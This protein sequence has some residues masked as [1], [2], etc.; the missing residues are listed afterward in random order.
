M[1]TLAEELAQLTNP[2]PV[3]HDPE[4]SDDFYTSAKVE[5]NV[6]YHD[7]YEVTASEP[8][9]LR[10]KAVV[11]LGDIDKKYAGKKTSR[12][13]LD[14]D[15]GEFSDDEI[16][17]E[18]EAS[19]DE[20]SDDSSESM[21]SGDADENISDSD[22]EGG[23]EEDAEIE[24]FQN[25][26]NLA[27]KG[28]QK[29]FSFVDDGDYSKYA[30]DEDND[31]DNDDDDDDDDDDDIEEEEMDN[32]DGIEAVGGEE[33]GISSFSKTSADE[34]VQKGQAAKYQLAQ[35]M[36]KTLLDKLIQLQTVLMLQNKE[37]EHIIT[38]DKPETLSNNTIQKWNDKTRL[39]GGK[40][41][42]KS[43]SAF[44]LSA[45]KQIEQILSD[46]DRL[47]KRTQMKR[48]VYKVLGKMDDGE[49]KSDSQPSDTVEEST[50]IEEKHH[51]YDPEIFDD[52][53]FYHQQL[54]E[55]IER[56]TSDINDPIA[57]SRQWLEIQKMRNKVKKKVD[58]RASKGRK[59]RY[60]VHSKLVNFMAP[61][62]NC[63][64]T[65]DASFITQNYYMHLIYFC[66]SGQIS[67]VPCLE[68][69]LQFLV[70][71]KRKCIIYSSVFS[72]KCM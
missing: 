48:S 46:R 24:S 18:S 62:D 14:D 70:T 8:S 3:F 16:G 44:E 41:N 64:W 9:K 7:D 69:D 52:S 63:S 33:D 47:I 35:Q 71:D 45:L 22:G 61:V 20:Y 5:K 57:L 67:L 31:D 56:K 13:K 36:L 58:T 30:D 19:S 37:T 2:A 4:D 55:L 38:G 27:T 15:N 34:E 12:K 54:R 11:S 39:A 59:T 49:N 25:K 51:N 66:I 68:K 26:L 17:E 60:N 6:G 43:F 42:S 28:E 21:G 32:E 23:T 1:G 29:S 53:D 65:D 50:R 10:Q 72:E 40:I